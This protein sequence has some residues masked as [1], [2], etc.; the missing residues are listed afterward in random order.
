MAEDTT[1]TPDSGATS[2][3]ADAA[4]NGAAT[5]AAEDG[6]FLAAEA[7]KAYEQRDAIKAKARDLEAKVKGMQE[8]LAARAADE[9]KF[10]EAY[11]ALAQSNVANEA[12][13]REHAE[14]SEYAAGAVEAAMASLPEPVR[15]SMPQDLSLIGRL[16]LAQ[17][18]A[19]HINSK[20]PT[21]S[22]VPTTPAPASAGS[23]PAYGSPGYQEWARTASL[24]EVKESRRSWFARA[25]AF[26]R[27]GK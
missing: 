19:S 6:A 11:E 17:S 1:A 5:V 14:L 10:K 18:L 26:G 3:T 4:G 15:E 9:G 20:T 8:A 22:P 13:L 2:T 27:P 24:D 25:G 21:S 16:R 12:K 7:K 23:R